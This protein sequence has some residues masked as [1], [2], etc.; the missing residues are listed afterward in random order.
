MKFLKVFFIS[1]GIY[2]LFILNVGAVYYNNRENTN[3]PCWSYSEFFGDA[4]D[5]MI[6]GGFMAS[7]P[8]FLFFYSPLVIILGV[9]FTIAWVFHDIKFF[10]LEFINKNRIS[11]IVAI[12]VLSLFLPLFA[13]L[14]SSLGPPSF[15]HF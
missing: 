5:D 7:K 8:N 14:E 15:C 10:D 6:V 12:I 13:Q 9:I 3:S 11:W 1:I 2:F 4:C